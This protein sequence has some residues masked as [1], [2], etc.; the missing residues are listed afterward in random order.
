MAKVSIS[1]STDGG[2]PVA[3]VGIDASEHKPAAAPRVH[4]DEFGHL[5]PGVHDVSIEDVEELFG[6]FQRTDRRPRLFAKL[7][8]YVAQLSSADWQASIVVDGS[9]VM[10]K[11]DEP[12]DIDIMLVL[13][14]DWDLAAEVKPFEY[15]LIARPRV[16]KRYG[17]DVFAVRAASP[18]YDEWRQFFSQ[19]KPRWSNELG[20]P[21]GLQKGLLRIVA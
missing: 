3:S 13:P 19:I 2:G 14:P 6:S 9:F 7:K 5:P 16:R 4:I 8:E 21:D 11:V 1:H 12:D 17:F 18:E 15:N 20:L 10:S